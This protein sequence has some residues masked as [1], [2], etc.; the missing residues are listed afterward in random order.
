VSVAAVWLLVGVWQLTHPQGT[1]AML[2]PRAGP[3]LIVVLLG[4][5]MLFAAGA[6]P[7][8]TRQAPSRDGAPISGR[9]MR[10][11]GSGRREQSALRV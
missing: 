1:S 3:G 2:V 11:P 7:Q 8:L 10:Q 4:G 9:A 6:L 5:V